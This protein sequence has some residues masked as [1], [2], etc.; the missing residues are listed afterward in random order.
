MQF[1]A[2]KWLISNDDKSQN[3]TVR[4]NDLGFSFRKSI[5]L[6]IYKNGLFSLNNKNNS[7]SLTFYDLGGCEREKLNEVIASSIEEYKSKGYKVHNDYTLTS[8]GLSAKIKQFIVKRINK[9]LNI[10][11]LY[12]N[13]H[14]IKIESV[15][16]I[17]ENDIDYNTLINSVNYNKDIDII[18]SIKEIDDGVGVNHEYNMSTLIPNLENINKVIDCFHSYFEKFNSLLLERSH[19]LNLEKTY[20]TGLGVYILFNDYEIQSFNNYKEYKE[21]FKET[22]LNDVKTIEIEL[23]LCYMR[24]GVIH[25]NE[26]KL[27]VRPYNIKFTRKS[28]YDENAINIMET[29]IYKYINELSKEKTVFN[30]NEN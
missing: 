5:D 23:N 2:F 29:Y 10:Y 8:N 18:M 11:Y 12:V 30:R 19:E 22:E 20:S 13:K 16:N 6:N 27:T 25:N 21:S 17:K 4:L 1:N 28:T 3:V 26:F 15:L 9:W 7:I 24:D 14:V